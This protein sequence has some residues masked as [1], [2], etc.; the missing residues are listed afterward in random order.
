EISG[1]KTRLGE[2]PIKR[3]YLGE[4]VVQTTPEYDACVE[5]A[6]KTNLPVKDVLSAAHQAL[7]TEG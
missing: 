7:Q 1:V 3:S 6:H 4:T 5:I 2:I